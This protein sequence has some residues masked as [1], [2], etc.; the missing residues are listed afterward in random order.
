MD[1]EHNDF[2]GLDDE[3]ED[4][5][6]LSHIIWADKFWLLAENHGDMRVM[7][8]ELTLEIRRR[9]GFEW[10]PSSLEVLWGSRVSSRERKPLFAKRDAS[11][12]PYRV[13]SGLLV[14]GEKLNENGDT[15][16]AVEWRQI[17]AN[18][19]FFRHK[20][21]LLDRLGPVSSRF[22]AFEVTAGGSFCFGGGG[23]HLS[24]N[25]MQGAKAWEGQKLRGMLMT[26][27]KPD[28]VRADHMKRLGAKIAGI[29]ASGGITR[30][31]VRLLGQSFRWANFVLR[32]RR[33]NG[34][35]SQLQ[36][37][38]RYRSR[39]WFETVQS[40]LGLRGRRDTESLVESELGL[41]G[42]RKQWREAQC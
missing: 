16:C 8:E 2:C 10:K 26:K 35:R 7:I 34:E 22:K 30:T 39:L 20:R 32:D 40:E 28:E 19:T 12:V 37:A 24:Q 4:S 5:V 36:L 14:L 15:D 33:P 17:L 1:A 13:T 3:E 11:D 18:K 42:R 6:W 29:V 41:R 9:L 27:R 23:W 25:V 38:H 31:H 21:L